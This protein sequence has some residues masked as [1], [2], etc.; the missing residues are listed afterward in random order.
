MADR[1][2]DFATDATSRD[3][4][5]RLLQDRARSAGQV[6]RNANV[7][8]W[9][10]STPTGLRDGIDRDEADELARRP[11]QRQSVSDQDRRIRRFT[12]TQF[13]AHISDKINFNRNGDM[14]VQIQV[15]YQFKH[16]AEPLTDAF[17]IPLS[18]DVEVWKPYD[19]ADD[20]NGTGTDDSDGTG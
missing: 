20:S 16:L 3:Y 18:F 17:G 4:L 15:P 14:M 2:H 12:H 7:Q 11:R 8:N 9:A 5:E 1:G 13:V 6:R 10:D 19:D